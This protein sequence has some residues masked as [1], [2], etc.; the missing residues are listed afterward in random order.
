[1]RRTLKKGKKLFTCLRNSILKV[2]IF[3]LYPAKRISLWGCD[4]AQDRLNWYS[5]HSGAKF[6]V[7]H[8][9]SIFLASPSHIKNAKIYFFH[10]LRYC[11]LHWKNTTRNCCRMRILKLQNSSEV[12]QMELQLNLLFRDEK[13]WKIL[14]CGN[15]STWTAKRTGMIS[16]DFFLKG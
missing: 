13:S 16:R 15:L 10:K 5:G 14:V 7:G 1:M 6:I 2:N 3:A 12:I 9:I 8:N 4:V 11:W